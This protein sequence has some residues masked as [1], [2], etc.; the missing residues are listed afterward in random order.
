MATLTAAI[1]KILEERI[2]SPGNGTRRRGHDRRGAAAVEFALVL[3]VLITIVLGCVD[4]G[5]FASTYI[6]VTNAARVGASFGSLNPVTSVTQA[7]W[8]Q[9][10]HELVVAEMGDEYDPE[11]STDLQISPVI[12]VEADGQ[13]R[14]RVTVSYVFNT[15][16]SWPLLPGNM[17][18]SR[19]VEMR[20]IR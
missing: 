16:V 10:I 9:R 19:A 12:T 3:P 6:A 13:K 15:V 14:V 1:H 8:E 4:F 5:R 7:D 11:R 18:L 17:T 2:M 20:V